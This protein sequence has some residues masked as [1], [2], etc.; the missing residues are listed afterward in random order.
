MESIEIYLDLDGVLADF[1]KSINEKKLHLEELEETIWEM[2]PKLRGKSDIIMKQFFRGEQ[3]DPI[4]K[5]AKRVYNVYRGKF[6]DIMEKPG[7]FLDL[8]PMPG[9]MTLV[10]GVRG[11]NGGKLPHILT[12]PVQTEHCPEEKKQWCDKYLAGKYGR[13]ICQ[14]NKTEYAEPFAILIDD[15]TKNTVPWDAAGGFSVLHTG[16][17]KNTLRQV[18]EF[19]DEVHRLQEV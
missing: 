19:I 12:A 2:V 18:A 14:K 15:M 3:T 4:L 6:Y 7:F 16:N 5:K 1:D 11:L 10:N 9:Y 17:V 13:F 8:E